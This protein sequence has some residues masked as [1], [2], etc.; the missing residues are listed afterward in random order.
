MSYTISIFDNPD[1]IPELIELFATGLGETTIEHWKWRLFTDNGQPD[2]AFAVV[3]LDEN[4]KMAGVSSMLPVIYGNGENERK[5][6]QFCDWVVHPDHRGKGIIK[7]IYSYACDYFTEKGYDFILEFP[8]DNSYPIFKKYG[9]IENPNIGCMNSSKHFSVSKKTP[10]NQKFKDVDIRFTDN[11]PFINET[12]VGENRIYRNATFLRWKYDLN[13]D[14]EYRFISLWREECC[15][16][17]FVYTLT[18]G[19][20]RTAVNIYD[21][22]YFENDVDLLKKVFSLLKKTG[23]YISIWGC[24]NDKVIELMQN[25][26]LKYAGGTTRLMLKAISDKSLPEKLTLTRIDTDY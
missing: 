17:Y 18:R 3:A 4:G 10:I 5:C 21:W 8:N 15:I 11:C 12:F 1:R 7:M 24:Y 23:N 22:E 14:T 26:G 20:L 25:A 13:P 19:R 16:G 9:F 6:L 2:P